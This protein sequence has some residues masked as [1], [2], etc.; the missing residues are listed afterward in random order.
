MWWLWIFWVRSVVWG[1]GFVGYMGEIERGKMTRQLDDA[2]GGEGLVWV[3]W[4]VSSVWVVG[5]GY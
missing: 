1:L 2:K 4:S 3:V 5:G